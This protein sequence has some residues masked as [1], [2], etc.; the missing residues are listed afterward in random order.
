MTS[1]KVRLT[2]FTLEGGRI[3]IAGEAGDVSQAY[4]FFEYVKKSPA[5]QD[6]DWTARQPQLAGKTKVRFEM[7]GARPDAKI[8]NE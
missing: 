8:S 1:D 6:Y 3:L 7:E 2:Q 4:Q 5:L